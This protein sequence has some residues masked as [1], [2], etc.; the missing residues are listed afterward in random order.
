MMELGIG[1]NLILVVVLLAQQTQ[2]TLLVRTGNYSFQAVQDIPAQFGPLIPQTGLSGILKLVDPEDACSQLR[3]PRMAKK[4]KSSFPETQD[5][6]RYGTRESK[7]TDMPNL[8]WIALIS[9]S[10]GSRHRCT[11]DV[12]VKHAEKQGAAAAVIYDDVY[13]S[14]VIMSKPVENPDPQIPSIFVSKSSGLYLRALVEVS[15]G[16]S[17][18]EVIITPMSDIVWVSMFMS[19]MAGFFAISIVMTA[20]CLVRHNT[21]GENELQEEDG[22]S[23]SAMT[24]RQ[25]RTLKVVVFHAG[26]DASGEGS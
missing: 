19:V 12:K 23:Q 3:S 8:P 24:K 1:V 9:R 6:F 15:E 7:G 14:L 21:N 5:S 13:E 26:D 11:F 2:G 22:R 17:D 16:A 18:V 25:L 20:F 10:H 4:K